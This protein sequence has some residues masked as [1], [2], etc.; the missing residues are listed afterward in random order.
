MNNNT[1]TTPQLKPCPFCQGPAELYV[2]K[3]CKGSYAHCYNPSCPVQ[4]ELQDM[5][6]SV[7]ETARVWNNRPDQD[8][9]RNACLA[10]LSK[11]ADEKDRGTA[12][13]ATLSHLADII[14]KGEHL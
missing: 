14:S 1:P 5:H 12:L 2:F 11:W 6:R 7:E 9:E 4:P 13:G 8:K 10:L 3:T